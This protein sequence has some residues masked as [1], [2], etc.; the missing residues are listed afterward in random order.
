MSVATM[1]YNHLL[2]NQCGITT[3]SMVMYAKYSI[4]SKLLGPTDY[5]VSERFMKISAKE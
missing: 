5:I 4:W 1:V 3:V 2:A